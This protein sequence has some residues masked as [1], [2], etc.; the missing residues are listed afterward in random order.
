MWKKVPM[1]IFVVDLADAV[2][3]P[4]GFRVFG[5]EEDAEK[6]IHEDFPKIKENHPDARVFVRKGDTTEYVWIENDH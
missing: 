1:P 5:T 2:R 4:M 6:F 3:N